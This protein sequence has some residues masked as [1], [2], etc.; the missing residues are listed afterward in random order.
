MSNQPGPDHGA[1]WGIDV[2]VGGFF[3]I[4]L[5]N[6]IE[7]YLLMFETF[8]RKNTLYF[9]TILAANTGV[10]FHLLYAFQLWSLAPNIPMAVFTAL[11]W[12]MMSTGQSLVLYL[13][14]H[15]VVHDRS[16]LRWILYLI[17][18]TFVTLQIP[19]TATFLALIASPPS[20]PP[21][22]AK[23]FEGLKIAQLAGF[24][25]QE[26]TISG[27][28]V[29]SF[30][31]TSK[32]L[33][34]VREDQVKKI[35]HELIALVII[36]VLFDIALIVDEIV[37]NYQVQTTLKPAVYSIKLKAELFV[38][39][40]LVS[41]MQAPAST[42]GASSSHQAQ[43]RAALERLSS[44]RTATS[45]VKS[46]PPC[47]LPPDKGLAAS[48][49]SVVLAESEDVLSQEKPRPSCP[50]KIKGPQVSGT[51]LNTDKYDMQSIDKTDPDD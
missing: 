16:K 50:Q 2:V 24:L 19:T 11:G 31:I 30:N 36:V 18:F 28:Y 4:A 8:R 17:T 35:L 21:R 12:V 39:N 43:R 5:Y 6:S 29:Y 7:V 20:S 3:G 41:W 26:A 14:L 22:F 45:E 23:A 44:Q 34:M 15:L 38:L 37:G 32:R 25:I 51:E 42:S 13:R 33:R 9:W 48:G 47:A 27:V 46:P 1:T 40:N 10:L 49:N